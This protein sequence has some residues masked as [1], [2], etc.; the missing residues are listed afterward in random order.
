MENNKH[1]N[2]MKNKF[3]QF[4]SLITVQNNTK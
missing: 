2:I 3:S 4:S 1:F